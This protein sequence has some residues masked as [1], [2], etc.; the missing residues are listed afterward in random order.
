[1]RLLALSLLLAIAA[2]AGCDSGG[3]GEPE[4]APRPARAIT[5]AELTQH[6]AALEKIADEHDGNRAAGTSGYDASA[7]YVAAR[8]R[9]AGWRVRFDEVTFPYFNLRRASVTV[10]GR[11]L[12]RERDFSVLTYSGF[13]SVSSHIRRQ[14]NGCAPG[15][16]DRLPADE[17]PV[18]RRGN[19]YFRTKAAN[20]QRAGADRGR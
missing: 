14:G 11:T 9:D 3:G 18:V 1:M 19:C 4:P 16:F 20:A 13:G 17:I 7:D 8:L 5:S 2:L 15:E 10:G 12:R 6:L